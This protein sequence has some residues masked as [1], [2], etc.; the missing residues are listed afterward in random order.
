MDAVERERLVETVDGADGTRATR[1]YTH[2]VAAHYAMADALGVGLTVALGP[3][4][5]VLR[6]A[7][8]CARTPGA[9]C[10]REL[11]RALIGTLA[12]AIEQVLLDSSYFGGDPYRLA[13]DEE[14]VPI[15]RTSGSVVVGS[16]GNH[17]D[18]RSVSIDCTLA[19]PL[20]AD[21]RAIAAEEDPYGEHRLRALTAVGTDVRGD[22]DAVLFGR[23]G[24]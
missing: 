20:V 24:H 23:R 15:C 8:W 6:D 2:D 5:I 1:T 14:Q 18:K 13:T 22:M 4:T 10:E 12:D 3:D 21:L 9:H 11:P 17:Y 19:R 16:D 7:S